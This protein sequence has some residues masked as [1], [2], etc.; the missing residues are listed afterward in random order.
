[1]LCFLDQ[2]KQAKVQ[3]LEDPNQSNVDEIRS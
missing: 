3:W 2:R 1:M